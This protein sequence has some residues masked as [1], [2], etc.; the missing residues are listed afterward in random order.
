MRA[1]VLAA[2]KGTR[3]KSKIPKVLHPL[4]GRPMIEWVIETA[5]KVAQ[6]VGVVLGFEAELVRKAL[7]EWVDV[8]VQGEQLGTAHAVM[9]AKDFIEPGDDVLILY[10]DVPLISENTL[11][12]MIEEH[13]KGADVTILVADLEDPSGYGRVIQ[14]GDKY[15]IIEDTDL[16]EELKSVT[17]IN[18][19]FY[20]FSGDFLLRALPEIKNENAKGEYYLTDAVNFAEKVRVVRTDDLLE[21]T[22]VNTR[23]TLVWLEE[24]LRMRK[25]EELLENGVTIL[26]PATT[27]I[28]Y[29]VEIGMDTVIYPMTF[30]E[31]KSRVGENCEIGPMT[32]IV[33]CEIGNNV[34]ITRSECFKSVIE[35]DVS[36]GPFARLRE[37]TILKKSSKIGNF[38]EIKKSTIGE[39]T[40]A[41]HLSYIGDAFVGKNV[42]VGA[43][44]I[45]C[46]YDGK[47]KNPTFI[48]DGAFIGSNSSLVAPVRIGKG[49]LIGAGSVITEDVPPYSLG[50]GRAR[51][52]VKEGWVL[53]KRKEE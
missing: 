12:R 53:K 30:I 23:K 39:G 17:T 26:D 6:K 22:G 46:N 51:Q 16:P 8:F 28:H 40:K 47:K 10:G 45:T 41:Q 42:N 4:S 32:R 50:L 21:I 1:L 48:E 33:D 7:P 43:G 44:T 5:G 35:D 11:K 15:R 9:C 25:I 34:K 18:T 19:G 38:V 3:M 37:G 14:D 20:V 52:V 2:G 49:A 31:G 27:Y 36:V 29:S 24:Q 13:R